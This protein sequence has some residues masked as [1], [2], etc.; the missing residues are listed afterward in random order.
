MANSVVVIG[1]GPAGLTA[2]YELCKAGIPSTVLEKD[3]VVGGL[4]RTASY[5]GYLFD[6]GGHR[7]FT[8]VKVVDDLWREILG[9]E[10]FLRRQRLSRIYYNKRFF[11]YPLQAGNALRGLGLWNSGLIVLSY[12]KAQVFPEKVEE[13]FEQWVSN[14]FGRRLY[15]TFFKAYTEKVW[16][17]PCSEIRAEWAA[18]RIKGLSLLTAVKNA[19]LTQQAAHNGS[20]VIKT[21]IEAFDYPE[22]GPGMMWEAVADIVT[23]R[24]NAVRLGAAVEKIEWKPGAVTAV[25]VRVDGRSERVEGTHF[26]NSM[27][28]RELIQAFE[29][30]VPPAVLAAAE[31]LKYRDFLTVALIVNTP[32]LFPD[33][34]IYV[35]DP[36]MRVGRIQNYK[37]WSPQMVPD[38]S[39]TCLGLE[40][41]CF[42]GDGLWTMADPDLVELGRQELDRLGLA[43][44]ADVE[45]G[46]VVR[47]PKAYPVYD[48]TYAQSLKT[49]RAF[50]DGLGNLQT[51]G[52]NGMH[53][54]NNQDHSM[55]TAMLAAENILG[56]AHDI[57]NVNTEPDYHEEVRSDSARAD[58]ARAALASTQPRVPRR[59]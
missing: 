23:Q 1:A 11:A 52:R 36:D 17:I 47:M 50:L 54:Y 9:E 39:K 14:R 59:R 12:L 40:Y 49:V 37:N 41:F 45:D 25:R 42:E 44:A 24:G 6:I 13:T 19:L 21:L 33:N 10:K 32:E 20:S 4:A 53:K 22:R 7:F 51:V 46:T 3:T 15:S 35:H 56:A 58:D 57:W 31:D 16:G 26:V 27:P 55:L 18:Q 5:K 43:R 34:W 29:P 38:A 30:A 28:I 8:K 2:A 48:S